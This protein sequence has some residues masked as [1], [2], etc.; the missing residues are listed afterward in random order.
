MMQITHAST[1]AAVGK[2]IPNPILAFIAGIIVHFIIDKIPHFWPETSRGK[3]ILVVVD[4]TFTYALFLA[5]CFF[6]VGTTSMLYGA[7][8]SLVVD[9]VIIGIPPIF[10]GKIGRWHTNRQPHILNPI[11]MV[12]DVLVTLI[13]I[14]ILIY[15]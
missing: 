15:L 10:K 6:K 4:H 8:G 11:S 14:F 7:A 13:G 9:I 3:T 5:A 2:F 12:T 1:G